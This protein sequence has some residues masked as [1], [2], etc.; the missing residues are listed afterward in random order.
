MVKYSLTNIPIIVII[1][2]MKL[3]I[4]KL[5]KEMKRL[6]LSQTDLADKMKPSMTRQGISFL[7]ASGKTKFA[8]V[9]SLAKVFDIDSKDLII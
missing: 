6:K 5:K 9:D 2:I 8:T 7:I 1:K 4:K 3:N